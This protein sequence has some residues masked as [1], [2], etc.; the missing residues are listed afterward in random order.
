[1]KLEI[2]KSIQRNKSEHQLRVEIKN[3]KETLKSKKEIRRLEIQKQI[4]TSNSE[5]RRIQIQ[6]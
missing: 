6:K 3:M 5:I 4:Q 2:P 1:M